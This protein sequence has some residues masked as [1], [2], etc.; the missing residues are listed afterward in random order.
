[1]IGR[2]RGRGGR[3]GFGR[4]VPIPAEAPNT[5]A[6]KKEE[7]NNV[8]DYSEEA[9]SEDEV[10][11][12]ESSIGAPKPSSGA[13]VDARPQLHAQKKKQGWESSGGEDEDD[14]APVS[15]MSNLKTNGLQNLENVKF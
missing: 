3:G 10:A 8:S 14:E 4:G 6:E 5:E 7:E 11:A 2:G 12:Q 9:I 15:E 1:M 13:A